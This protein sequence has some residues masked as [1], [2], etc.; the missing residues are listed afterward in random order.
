MPRYEYKKCECGKKSPDRLV[1]MVARDS[2]GC[3][4]CSK[5]LELGISAPAL[6]GFDSNG[7]SIK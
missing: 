2:Q 6:H 1:P 7:S 3:A 4:W 5:R